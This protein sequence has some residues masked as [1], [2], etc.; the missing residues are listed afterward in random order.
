MQDIISSVLPIFLITMLGS[1]IKRNWLTAEEFWRG[2]EK[3]S[4]FLLFP[5]LLFNN[6]A[7]ADFQN[8]MYLRLIISLVIATC[9]VGAMLIIYNK[10][11]KM[12][13]DQFSSVFQGGIRYNNYI[14]F[15][16][17][18]ALFGKENMSTLAIISAY[19]IIFTNAISVFIF[20]LY[21]PHGDGKGHDEPSLLLLS[22]KIVSN[23]LIISSIIGFIFNFSGAEL[24]L[25]IY[26]T[27][28]TLSNAALAIGAMNVGAGLRF[29]IDLEDMRMISIASIAK[30]F[31]MPVITIIVLYS[32]GITG[33]AFA[34]GILYSTLP[35]ASTSYVL[36]RQ[37]GGDHELMASVITITTIASVLTSSLWIYLIS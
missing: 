24:D 7:H 22:K 2:L 4:Y 35:C 9:I 23:P 14:F 31:I 3:L 17:G 20:A 8:N 18:A 36:A 16:M 32:F 25:S 5:L 12:P 11:Y 21:L 15:A 28:E 13:A 34:I 19:M 37:L 10:R 26:K 29:N 6:I 1:L 30:L 33:T 27:L